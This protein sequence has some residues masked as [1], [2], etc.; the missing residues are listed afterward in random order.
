MSLASSS[1]C[2]RAS[3][4]NAAFLSVYPECPYRAVSD[5]EID[6]WNSN[7]MSNGR[8]QVKFGE[9]EYSIEVGTKFL[10]GFT[11]NDTAIRLL[12]AREL[13]NLL[14]KMSSSQ[15]KVALSDD[16]KI[17]TFDHLENKNKKNPKSP[18][19]KNFDFSV[20][21][22]EAIT[23]LARISL[24]SKEQKEERMYALKTLFETLRDYGSA[25]T[26]FSGT[27]KL[28]FMNNPTDKAAIA[29][30]AN[31]ILFYAQQGVRNNDEA[32]DFGIRILGIN[33]FEQ[34]RRLSK[35]AENNQGFLSAF[36]SNIEFGG[37]K[38][39]KSV[40][41]P[42][43]DH[44]F[45]QCTE[46]QFK[47]MF[48]NQPEDVFIHD[49]QVKQMKKAFEEGKSQVDDPITE[50][51]AQQKETYRVNRKQGQA[52]TYGRFASLPA[53]H[54]ITTYPPSKNQG[55][56]HGSQPQSPLKQQNYGLQNRSV[57]PLQPPRTVQ[58]PRPIARAVTPAP[59]AHGAYDAYRA[60]SH[61]PTRHPFHHTNNIHHGRK[62]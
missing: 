39:A 33:I 29:V 19:R 47:K 15:A 3:F 8:M 13:E 7:I 62:K 36:L 59:R 41:D 40:H 57:I 24:S 12:F 37:A 46:E 45:R 1:H 61:T 16:H 42:K 38:K 32:F 43:C 23:D 60:I 44:I 35:K 56:N 50:E 20:P 48:P 22:E 5:L 58:Q 6:H 10:P 27:R 52:P 4:V 17:T 49:G 9:V 25:T 28:Y 26:N 14:Q 11:H 18:Q 51:T 21:V 53:S 34:L 31:N 55:Y 30:I 2:I 54:P